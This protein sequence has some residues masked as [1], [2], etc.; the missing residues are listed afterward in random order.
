LSVGRTDGNNVW[1]LT[2]SDLEKAA[3]QPPP[4]F[5]GTM[6]LTVE[7]RT[8]D[9]T[10]ADRRSLRFQWAAPAVEGAMAGGNASRRLAPEEVASLLKRADSLIASRD[11]AAARLVLRRAAEAGDARGA[12]LLASTYDPTVL[13][14]LGVHGIVPDAD[15]ARTWYETAKQL[16]SAE[17]SRRLDALASRRN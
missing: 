2:A 13:A 3:I 5:T 14:G 6:D 17:A 1:T 9:A 8:A 7:L 16:G 4:N 11:V 10:V 12:M 15:M